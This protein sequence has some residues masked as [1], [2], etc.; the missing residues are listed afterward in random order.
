MFEK[1]RDIVVNAMFYDDNDFIAKLTPQSRLIEDLFLDSLDLVDII[2]DIEDEF[3][4]SVEDEVLE[5]IRT[6][7]ELAK[8]VEE[9]LR[10]E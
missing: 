4:V 2:M 3:S 7:G 10:A 8:A 5:T 6:L 9:A 1:I